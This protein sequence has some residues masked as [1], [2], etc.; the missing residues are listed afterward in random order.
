M[1]EDPLLCPCCGGTMRIISFVTKQGVI[2]KILRHV[3]FK[4]A[5]APEIASI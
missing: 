2:D 4:H 1:E 3:G 5:D